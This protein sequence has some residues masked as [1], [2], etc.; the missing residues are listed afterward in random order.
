ML[1]RIK[2]KGNFTLEIE[3]NNTLPLFDESKRYDVTIKEYKNKRS[4]NQNALLWALI[5]Q[6]S[7]KTGHTKDEIYV[8]ALESVGAKKERIEC[9]L[10]ESI[11]CLRSKYRAVKPVRINITE[12]NIPIIEYDCYIGSSKF[13]TAEM[14]KL[15]DYVQNL[16]EEI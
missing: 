6:L 8:T 3:F 12:D 16:V 5:E 1:A 14:T 11:D 15:I 7:D 13:N 10:N 2:N 4:L 9:K